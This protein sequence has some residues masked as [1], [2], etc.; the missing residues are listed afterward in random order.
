MK[1]RSLHL[2][3][4][5]ILGLFCLSSCDFFNDK[6]APAAKVVTDTMV[7]VKDSIINAGHFDSIPVG[8]YQG[9]LPCRNCEAIQR[10]IL[11]SS[12]EHF[13]MEELELGKS[14]PAKRTEGTWEHDKGKFL[15]YLNNKVLAQYRL[16]KDSLINLENNGSRIPDSMSR[17]YVLFKK[18]TAPENPAW[19]QKATE[20]VDILG[21]GSDPFWSVE[22]DNQKFILF[23]LATAAKP[24]IVPIEKPSVAKDSMVYSITTEG[25]SPLKISVSPGFCNDGIGDHL[26]EYRMKVWYRGQLYK[27][28]AVKLNAA[29]HE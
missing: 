7:I 16:T 27:G 25:G 28:C 11:F 14:I 18:N 5:F 4:L 8:F 19:R 29:A 1:N 17:Q 15:L 2:F 22:I 20:G 6:P 26:Y 10:T 9:M 21:I 3:I 13:T 23:K 24:V 12:D